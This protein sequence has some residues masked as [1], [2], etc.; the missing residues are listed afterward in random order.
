[1]CED[2]AERDRELEE[3]DSIISRLERELDEATEPIKK[4]KA[5]AIRYRESFV[6]PDI[7]REAEVQ[8]MLDLI[9]SAD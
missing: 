1:M 4:L 5:H 7:D 2:C 3:Q 9:E 8:A 6:F